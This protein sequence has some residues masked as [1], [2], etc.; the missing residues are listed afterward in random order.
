M[1]AAA[2][3][4]DVNQCLQ[5]IGFTD[6][7]HHNSIIAE[8]GFNSLNDFIDVMETDIRDRAKSFSKCSPAANCINFGM[9]RLSP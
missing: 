1:A 3:F 2:A 5:W 4:A 8:G 6:V 7:Q 9:R